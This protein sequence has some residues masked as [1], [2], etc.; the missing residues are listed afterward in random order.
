MSDPL[1]GFRAPRV[2]ESD[3]MMFL[4]A[5]QSLSMDEIEAASL[6]LE[7]REFFAGRIGRRIIERVN[8]AERE[9]LDYV[10]QGHGFTPSTQEVLQ[11]L[12][13][14][15]VIATRALLWLGDVI[16]EGAEAE[17]AVEAAL[18]D[19]PYEDTADVGER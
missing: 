14:D 17:I 4:R 15:Y 18:A 7:V 1:D 9:F 16:A 6:S 12:R 2:L 19:L 11:Q 3:E 5:A 10:K 13:T 8:E